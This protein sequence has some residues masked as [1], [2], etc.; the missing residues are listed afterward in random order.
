MA[1]NNVFSVSDLI[2]HVN[3]ALDETVVVEGEIS[4]I[5]IRQNNLIF[6]T[7]TD[8]SSA[9]DIFGLVFR[10]RN[11]SELT[12]GMLVRVTGSPGLYKK[13]G[14]FRI[15]AE[16]IVPAGE[17]ALRIAYEKLKAKLDSEGLFDIERKRILPRFPSRLALITAE[18]SQ[19]YND[20]VKVLG[21]RFGGIDIDYYPVQVQGISAVTSIVSAFEALQKSQKAY[22]AIILTRGGGS[23]ED[24]HAFNSEEVA[25]AVFGAPYPVVCGVGHEGDVSLADLV[26]D[27]R[28]STPSNA[29]EL[30]VPERETV[31][32]EIQASLSQFH[33]TISAEIRSAQE[34]LSRHANSM[35]YF[36]DTTTSNVNMHTQ[37]LL[38]HLRDI[39]SRHS[40]KIDEISSYMHSIS[41]AQDR[42]VGDAAIAIQN[43]K[44]FLDT[45]DHKK[46]LQKGYSVTRAKNGTIVKTLKDIKKGDLLEVEIHKG[47]LDTEVKNT[48]DS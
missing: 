2:D 40:N 28:A 30:L 6:V 36:L 46:I 42:I 47:R 1:E 24:L 32:A 22:D 38:Y 48:H 7:I 25:R 17:G 23:L 8:E 34:Q 3:E 21:E 20:F 18:K 15:D 12:E 35:K 19:A 43:V 14:R 44:R 10:I 4:R 39:E 26:A 29:A 37:A 13:S 16:S 27:L 45:Q 5:D 33:D 11:V 9:I 41:K 31:L